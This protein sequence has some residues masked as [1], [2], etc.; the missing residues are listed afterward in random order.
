MEALHCAL[1]GNSI[2]RYGASFRN[3]KETERAVL[4]LTLIV[5]DLC[6]TQRT[7]AIEIHHRYRKV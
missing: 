7:G 5:S 6:P 4:I 3:I 1:L 2:R